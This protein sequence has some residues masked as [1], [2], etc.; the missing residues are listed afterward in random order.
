MLEENSILSTLSIR[1][2]TKSFQHFKKHIASDYGPRS[3]PKMGYTNEIMLPLGFNS[4]IVATVV[5]L[6]M[7]V[8]PILVFNGQMAFNFAMNVF[9]FYQ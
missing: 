5:V 8:E 2:G 1:K 7:T 9:I 6:I 3:I 4:N